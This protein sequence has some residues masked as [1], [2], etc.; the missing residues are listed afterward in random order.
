MPIKIRAVSV[1][2]PGIRMKNKFSLIGKGESS[3]RIA[4]TKRSGRSIEEGR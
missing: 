4:V 3:G 1:K 2:L